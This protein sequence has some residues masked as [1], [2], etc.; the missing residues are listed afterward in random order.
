[1]KKTISRKQET[2]ADKEAKCAFLLLGLHAAAF[3]LCI[4]EDPGKT[5]P[6]LIVL[7]LYALCILRLDCIQFRLKDVGALRFLRRYWALA[8]V[9]MACWLVWGEQWL[10]SSNDI[11]K[12]LGS[13]AVVPYCS[14]FL[15]SSQSWP[16]T[17]TYPVSRWGTA[18]LLAL[19][20]AHFI[21][22]ILL[23]A[24][25]RDLDGPVDL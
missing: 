16:W 24:K 2:L 5:V 7:A 17:N 22:Y 9:C 14:S 6:R 10:S 8:A 11:L 12:I 20:L 18:A 15:V 21:Y 4:Q 13:I 3:L 1:M 23:S 19:C 25:R